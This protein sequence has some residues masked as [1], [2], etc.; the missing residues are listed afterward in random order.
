MGRAVG[1]V[2][3]VGVGDGVAVFGGVGVMTGAGVG[4]G[5]V[6]A[7][8]VP[9]PAAAVKIRTAMARQLTHRP[10]ITGSSYIGERMKV[11]ARGSQVAMPSSASRMTNQAGIP[12]SRL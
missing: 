5:T 10:G 11:M 2:V 6:V 8:G 9:Q 7:T 1:A 4:E 3:A 12:N